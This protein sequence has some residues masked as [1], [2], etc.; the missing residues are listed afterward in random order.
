MTLSQ[1]ADIADL[2]AAAGVILSLAFVYL[3]LRRGNH[4]VPALSLP[5]FS[6]RDPFLFSRH[7]EHGKGRT[8]DTV[9]DQLLF[10]LL[11]CLVQHLQLACQQGAMVLEGPGAVTE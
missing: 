9:I 2:L 7:A 6:F 1:I 11:T 5:S 8:V 3:E 10:A 4:N